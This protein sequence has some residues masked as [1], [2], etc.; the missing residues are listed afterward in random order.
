MRIRISPLVALMGLLICN[1]PAQAK[2]MTSKIETVVAE[3]MARTGSQGIAIAVI[4]HG[5]VRYVN[6]WGKRNAKGDPLTTDT[7]MYGASLTKSAF[8]YLVAQLADEGKIDLDASIATY[9]PK[10]LPE[11]TNAEDDYAPW[12]HLAG[13]ERWRKLTPRI[14][15]N[16]ASGFANFYWLNPDERLQFRFD[17]GTRYSYSGDGI[18]LLQFVL[19]KGL[20]LSVEAELQRRLFK[21]LGM[22]NTSLIWQPRFAENLADG[23][24]EDGAVEPHDERSRVR[25]AGSM[26]TSIA[27]LSKL[28]A[29]LMRGDHLSQAAR[30]AMVAPQLPIRTQSQF[31]PLQPEINPTPFPKLAAGLGVISFAGPQGAGFQKGG[32]NDSTGNTLLCLEKGKRCVLILSNDVRSEQMFPQIVATIL[33][34]TGF[35]WKWEY[36][37]Q[38]W[39]VE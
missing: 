12:Q 29:A 13:D 25:A 1:S 2:T 38:P 8:A 27:D 7:I 32:H 18:M 5:K 11:Y 31:P 30:R 22:T 17:P 23:W 36:G 16:H 4:E 39:A 6:S 9:L 34:K 24:K 15:L 14:L 33:G 35:P 10:P 20:G 3:G 28:F 21:P 19:E 37:D 26:D